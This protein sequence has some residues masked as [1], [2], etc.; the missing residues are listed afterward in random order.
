MSGM[1]GRE[2]KWWMDGSELVYRGIEME[3]FQWMMEGGSGIDKRSSARRFQS[4]CRN[5]D[6]KPSGRAAGIGGGWITLEA[7]FGVRIP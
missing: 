4:W 7:L 2:I 6:V 1:V 5:A 3:S